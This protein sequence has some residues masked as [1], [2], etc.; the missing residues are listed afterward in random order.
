[1]TRPK[2][3]VILQP[4]A[5]Q[6][7]KKGFDTLA[8]LLAITLGP[9]RGMVLNSPEL[10]ELPEPLSD[11][12][13][14]AR[15]MLGLPDRAQNVGAMLL[16][17]LVWRVHQTVGDGSATTAVLAQAIL[18]QAHRYV[19]AG[20]NAMVVQRGVKKAVAVAVAALIEQAQTTVTEEDLVAVALGVTSEPELSF[21]L[22]EMYELLGPAAHISIEDYV[23][24]YL[25]RQYL[26]GGHWN[27]RLASAYLITAPTTRQAILKRCYVAIYEGDL[28]QEADIRPLLALIAEKKPANLLLVAHKIEGEALNA[29]VTTHTN[30]EMNILAANL[31]RVGPRRRADIHDLAILT[32]AQPYSSD[33]GQRL[34]NISADDLGSARRAEA[35]VQEL[36]VVGG[37]GNS[38]KIRELINILQNRKS[39]LPP[40]DDA[41]AELQMRLARLSGSAAILK[42]GAHTK[43]ERAV[44]HQKAQQSIKAL[45]ATL[46]EGYLPGGGTAYLHCIS[47]IDELPPPADQ[48]EL[49]GY[50]AVARALEAPFRRIL[51]NAGVTTAGVSQ[52]EILSEKP[53]LLFDVIQGK[54]AAAQ[55]ARIFDAAKVLRVALETAASGA[56]MAL[57]TDTIILK[58][59]PE[60]SYEP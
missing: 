2:P 29:L 22:G 43:T 39:A 37:E 41:H 40:G 54:T 50:K 53:G 19:T 9:L 58:Q 34:A 44:L 23:A 10:K 24:P 51:S 8:D 42:I 6:Q 59:H 36:F 25:E 21:I 28:S 14:I 38:T 46:E 55:S 20:A 17:H 1:M 26:E 13:T 60:M 16:R 12:A 18:A 11:A 30:S 15:R 5:T 45:S 33:L 57:S 52:A 7:L 3:A 56:T 48:D 35:T 49:F 31:Q 32:G 27:A 47:A 4:A